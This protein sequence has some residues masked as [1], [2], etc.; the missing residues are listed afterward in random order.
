MHNLLQ[1]Q[2]FYSTK[3]ISINFSVTLELFE[4][5]PNYFDSYLQNTIFAKLDFAKPVCFAPQPKSDR[6]ENQFATP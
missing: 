2:I 1:G 5:S 4:Q 6:H 3:N